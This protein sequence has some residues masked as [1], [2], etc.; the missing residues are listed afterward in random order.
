MTTT[1]LTPTA[2]AA[3]TPAATLTGLCDGAVHL[4][5]DPGYDA[6]RVP[7]NVAVDQRPAAVALPRTVAHVQEVVRAAAAAGLRVAP[8]STGHNAGPLAAQGLSDVVVVRTERMRGVTIDPTRRLA[9][10]EGGALWMDATEPA[11]DHRLAALHGSS[12]D[13]GIAGYSLGGGMGWYARQLGLAANSLTAVEL[14]TADGEHVRAD[15]TENRE[16][17]WALRGGGGNFG[18]VTALEFRLFPIETAY[19]GMLVWDRDHAER[20]LRRWADWAPGAPDAVTTSFRFLDVPPL[21]TVPEPIRGRSLVV[22]DGAVL[23]CDAEA[24]SILG[25]LRGLGP[26]IDTFG[27]M[28]ARALPRLHLDPEG[29]TPAVSDSTLVGELGD[30]A[31]DTLLE[32][33]GPGS[34]SSLLA[35]ELR[36]LGG[37]L[38]RTPEEHGALARIDAAYAVFAVAVAATPELA[39]QG[40]LDAER[41]TASL[42]PWSTGRSYLNF[43]EN[44]VDVSTGY[45]ASVWRQLKGI[46]SALDP[47]DRFLANHRVPRL[48]EDGAVTP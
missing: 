29:P 39:A 47:D 37:A 38:G 24:R 20:V 45:D 14:V 4:P 34:T 18:V 2:R 10:V 31:I 9:R 46:R 22:I 7:W 44:D 27:R 28:P 26:E 43:A 36:Q 42:R 3:T 40:Q 21:P 33:V 32:Q 6:A 8:Q 48:F 25:L 1:S 15:A 11:A 35:A 41:L 12:P 19:A 13:V 17:F 23:G 16:L 30:A 5:G